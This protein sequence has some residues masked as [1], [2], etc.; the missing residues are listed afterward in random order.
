MM[1]NI[2]FMVSTFH[3]GAI[4]LRHKAATVLALGVFGIASA[5]HLGAQDGAGEGSARLPGPPADGTMGFVVD[6][7]YAPIVPGMDACPEGLSPTMREAYL[8][9]R[10]PE[11]RTRLLRQENEAELKDR[12]QAEAFGPNGTNICSQPDLFDR[13]LLRTVQSKVS[14]G[15]D[16]DGGAPSCTHEE[17]TSPSGETGIDN[18]EYRAMGCL[19]QRRSRDGTEGEL[20]RGHRQFFASGEW[21][22]VLLLRGVDSLEND[23]DVEVIYG[24]TPDRPALDTKG[25]FLRGTSF[26]ISDVA[27]R[28]RNALRGSIVDGVL[29]TRPADIILTQTW[30][31]GGARDIRGHRTKFTFRAGRLK[32]QFKPDGSLSGLIGGYRPVFEQ[33]QSPAIGG[34]G[35]AVSAGIDCASHLA[36][37]KK[38]ADGIP[39]PK[40]GQCTAVSSAMQVNAI[41]AYVNDVAGAGAGAGAGAEATFGQGMQP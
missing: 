3:G 18:Q 31:Q 14:W 34:L 11:E 6:Q 4:R 36:T 7:F 22:Q 37:L 33:I 1:G 24:N 20:V 41:P 35:A 19:A 40:T 38:L 2:D 21:T 30:G 12:W 15:L 13:P 27:P 39:D 28:N 25:Q 32:L 9:T 5:A 8:E 16:L 29:I 26:T 17:F 23:P 10:P